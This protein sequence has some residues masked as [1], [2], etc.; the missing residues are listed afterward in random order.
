MSVSHARPKFDY[1][2]LI[3]KIQKNG[4]AEQKQE[5]PTYAAATPQHRYKRRD[6]NMRILHKS[7]VKKQRHSINFDAFDSETGESTEQVYY[8]FLGMKKAS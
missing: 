1:Q 8:N 5:S 3:D 7:I 6:V 2:K 4:N